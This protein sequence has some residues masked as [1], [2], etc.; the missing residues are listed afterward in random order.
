TLQLI[1][2]I[3]VHTP[4]RVASVL[5]DERG[6]EGVDRGMRN[7]KAVNQLIAHHSLIFI[8]ERLEVCVSANRYQRGAYICYNLNDIF[9]GTPVPGVAIDDST[10]IIEA[11]PFLFSKGYEDFLKYID[12][13][14]KLKWQLKND[15]AEGIS[16]GDIQLLVNLNPEFFHARFIAGE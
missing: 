10:A 2:S 4:Q 6:I 12:V 14:A 13:L 3:A 1:D 7:E 5:R 16:E 8:P 11:D 9:T 15:D